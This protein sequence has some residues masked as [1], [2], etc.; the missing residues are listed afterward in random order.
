[1]SAADEE[2]EIDDSLYRLVVIM[3][4]AF[5]CYY[6]LYTEYSCVAFH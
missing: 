2:M 3:F 5:S 6:F 4:N 1:M